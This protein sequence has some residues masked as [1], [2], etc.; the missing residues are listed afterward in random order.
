MPLFCVD[1]II[2]LEHRVGWVEG[3]SHARKQLDSFSRFDRIPTCDRQT[4]RQTDT[5]PQLVP[6]L[7]QRRAGNK[8]EY[9]RLRLE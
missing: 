2:S 6:A 4:D 8:T 1:T 3:S 9:I 5:G 7:A